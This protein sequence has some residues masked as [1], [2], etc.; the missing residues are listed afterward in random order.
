MLRR[1]GRQDL[2]DL[3]RRWGSGWIKGAETK[4]HC[5]IL[6][7]ACLLQVPHWTGLWEEGPHP[8]S[9]SHPVCHVSAPG[10]G[11]RFC[12]GSAPSS[13]SQMSARKNLLR[14][15][16]KVAPVSFAQIWV[17]TIPA[18]LLQPGLTREFTCFMEHQCLPTHHHGVA[19][20]ATPC[21]PDHV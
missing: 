13:L 12:L 6:S 10:R 20:L 14:E 19:Q 9:P 16:L 11:P 4:R 7:A 8:A 18:Y 21:P 1:L 3:G 17:L 5:L 15:P 2:W